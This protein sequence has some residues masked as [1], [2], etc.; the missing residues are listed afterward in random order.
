MLPRK[1]R[2]PDANKPEE[3]GEAVDS[4]LSGTGGAGAGAG[5]A[6]SSGSQSRARR[7]RSAES[8][9]EFG[10]SADEGGGSS[11]GPKRISDTA[12]DEALATALFHAAE[13]PAAAAEA[14]AQIQ[15]LRDC[16]AGT[17]KLGRGAKRFGAEDAL[18][19]SLRHRE[20]EVARLGAAALCSLAKAAP[21]LAL[22]ML[23]STDGLC[24][25]LRKHIS[26]EA[27]SRSIC[28]GLAVL[29]HA[30]PLE[31]Q[32]GL[33]SRGALDVLVAA[34]RQHPADEEI[35]QSALDGLDCGAGGP[36]V[37]AL[38]AGCSDAVV[39][40]LRV[41]A[42][43]WSTVSVGT[44]VLAAACSTTAVAD[45]GSILRCG[46]GR[47]LA[48]VIVRYAHDAAI[49]HAALSTLQVLVSLCPSSAEQLLEEGIAPALASSLLRY[50]IGSSDST[51]V[52][53]G[54]WALCIVSCLAK[55]AHPSCL[56]RLQDA[57][58]IKGLNDQFAA[59]LHYGAEAAAAL[60]EEDDDED[61]LEEG[62][63]VLR[64]KRVARV[65]ADVLQRLV[66]QPPHG[67][68]PYVHAVL[69]DGVVPTMIIE[70]CCAALLGQW[71]AALAS[72]CCSILRRL[73]A[74]IRVLTLAAQ[75][76]VQSA[77]L[78]VLRQ[79]ND[80]NRMS[81]VFYEGHEYARDA[82]EL[83]SN[84]WSVN[85]SHSY[86]A[87][88][89]HDLRPVL[90]LLSQ[91]AEKLSDRAKTKAAAWAACAYLSLFER[92][93]GLSSARPGFPAVRQALQC[94]LAPMSA[95]RLDVAISSADAL[96]SHQLT[97]RMLFSPQ[98]MSTRQIRCDNIGKG[99]I[100]ALSTSSIGWKSVSPADAEKHAASLLALLRELA[101]I[102][103]NRRPLLALG[104]AHAVSAAVGWFVSSAKVC[105]RACETAGLLAFGC[106]SATGTLSAAELWHLIA[107]PSLARHSG[108]S[109]VAAAAFGAVANAVLCKGL[110]ST[111]SAGTVASEADIAAAVHAMLSTPDCTGD[112]VTAG[113]FLLCA[114]HL[115]TA[116][117][118]DSASAGGAMAAAG[119]SLFAPPALLALAR[120]DR[121][122]IEHAAAIRAAARRD[123]A[124]LRT[125]R[126]SPATAYMS[127]SRVVHLATDAG[128]AAALELLLQHKTVTSP[129][130]F[131][132]NMLLTSVAAGHQSVVH[133][134]LHGH[135][136]DP[137][138][139]AGEALWLA[140]EAGDV[141]MLDVLLQSPA[142]FDLEGARRDFIAARLHDADSGH[143]HRLDGLY[144][145]H[146]QAACKRRLRDSAAAAAANGSSHSTAGSDGAGSA[147]CTEMRAD[148]DAAAR[149][150]S[151]AVIQRLLLD[152]REDP[153]AAGAAAVRV[154]ARYSGNS[155]VSW[156]DWTPEADRNIV[157]QALLEDPRVD[158]LP[159]KA[160]LL[161]G[162]AMDPDD[163]ADA[164]A[165]AGAGAGAGATARPKVSISA[166]KILLRQPALLRG[167]VLPAVGFD[168]N[169][170]AMTVTLEYSYDVADVAA[171]CA[172]AWRRRRA[173][174][175]A[176][177]KTRE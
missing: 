133:Q 52:E 69:S 45:L 27:F 88:L 6:D 8:S 141:D 62:H 170:A 168:A 35:V 77:V 31:S 7:N 142:L 153:V 47:V 172:A 71:G 41:H 46:G 99:V 20:S 28:R 80:A 115:A 39:A 29:L 70:T 44:S 84:Q 117:A 146:R 72:P 24:F 122:Q 121:G 9:H 165:P 54:E 74:Q 155:H 50:P 150:T 14:K 175:L 125:L 161:V 10:E 55:E 92:G 22:R 131:A 102:E 109:K 97:E 137:R 61:D 89:L 120:A 21:A 118:T 49:V 73:S 119:G 135:Q 176:W 59:A 51:E 93:V 113:S 166:R 12:V 18:L 177:D 143:L 83:L 13:A 1:R 86:S 139:V 101:R 56:S 64:W 65:A 138:E 75:V 132:S 147:S 11:S 129:P 82:C 19:A 110:P 76:R 173:A 16:A 145:M 124:S 5:A 79:L 48:E 4:G 90:M 91:L 104:A 159:M 111:A 108:D 164:A 78:A 136:S 66:V 23:E 154:A 116:G 103:A 144:E 140:A 26:N 123:L 114:L 100:T 107:K 112:V 36:L 106:A 30:V 58:L 160:G 2:T 167:L 40:A 3:G 67:S 171:M 96:R 42:L 57:T 17:I 157:L 60:D 34:L 98:T 81:L 105:R 149:A 33:A 15:L 163:A 94:A 37:N 87:L 38:R 128:D 32:I 126:A 174:V 25:S 156:L 68:P 134:V 158:P 127:W 152:V 95:D 130:D 85:G 151:V 63:P 148:A 53:A 169:P 43:D 162:Y